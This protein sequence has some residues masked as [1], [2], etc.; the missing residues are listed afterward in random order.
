MSMMIPV[1]ESCTESASE[2]KVVDFI[3]SILCVYMLS[4]SISFCKWCFECVSIVAHSM[5]SVLINSRSVL[6]RRPSLL[7]R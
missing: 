3:L 1:R 5:E 4:G 2:Q 7:S 6:I